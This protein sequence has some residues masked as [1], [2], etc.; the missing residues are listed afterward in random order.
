M[1]NRLIAKLAALVLF[2]QCLIACGDSDGGS[3]ADAAGGSGGSGGDQGSGSTGQKDGSAGSTA[4]AGGKDGGSDTKDAGGGNT[5]SKD[6]GD[7]GGSSTDRAD[8]GSGDND[9]NGKDDDGDGKTDEGYTP[10]D[11]ACG[12]GACA[13]TGSTSCVGGEVQDNCRPKTAAR[14]DDTCDNIDDDCDGKTDEDYV[15]VDNCGTGYC[16]THNT[17]SSCVD[18]VETVC[19]PATRLNADDASCDSV[20]DDCD[21]AA[22]EGY[23]VDSS[24]GAGY[25]NSTNT[26][27]SCA[28]GVETACSPGSPLSSDDTTCDG[29][30][31]DCDGTDDDDYVVNSTCGTGY[32]ETNNTPSSCVGGVETLCTAA[33]QNTPDDKGCNG[34]D[35]DCDGSTDEDYVADASCG[36]GPCR[37]TNTPSTCVD[38]VETPC[39]SGSEGNTTDPTCDGVDDDCDGTPDDDYASVTTS[40]G[41]GACASTGATSCANGKVTDSCIAGDPAPS[42]ASCDGVDD[43]CDGTPDDDYVVDASC[44]IGE[45]NA[46][47]TPSSCAGGVETLC[48]AGT[49][50]TGVDSSCDNK[51][52][53]CDSSFDEDYVPVAS[54]GI[55]YCRQ[56]NTPSS[57]SGGVITDC[58]PSDPKS[59]TDAT[60]D[61]VDDDCDGASDEDFDPY[62]SGS[63]TVTCVDGGEVLTACDD[64]IICTE[65]ICTAG[66]CDV[67]PDDS[68]CAD[69]GVACTNERCVVGLGC[70]SLTDHNYCSQT[71]DGGKRCNGSERCEPEVAGDEV[72]CV[73]GTPPCGDDWAC[74]DIV[75]NETGPEVCTT[76]LNHA[77][78]QAA[79]GVFCNGAEQCNPGDEANRDANGCVAGSDPC[80][81]MQ[82]SAECTVLVCNEDTDSCDNVPDD[83]Y[84]CDDGINCTDD[85]CDPD[86]AVDP[87][88]C[89]WTAKDCSGADT[90]AIACTVAYC[91]EADGSCKINYSSELCGGDACTDSGCATCTSDADCGND[92]SNLCD[93][94]AACVT[95]ECVLTSPVIDCNDGKACTTDL[96]DGPSGTCNHVANDS[97]CFDGVCDGLDA[98]DPGDPSADATTGCV[99]AA[100]PDCDDGIACTT[101]LCNYLTGCYPFPNHATCAAGDTTVCNGEQF[102]DSGADPGVNPSGCVEP[103]PDG[104]D[105]DDGIPCTRDECVEPSGSNEGGCRSTND[106]TNCPCGQSCDPVSGGCLTTCT[107]TECQGKLYECGDCI[108]NDN[109]CACFCDDNTAASCPV[110]GSGNECECDPDCS[111]PATSCAC[112]TASSSC[113][114]SCYCD[115]DCYYPNNG[116]GIDSGSDLSCFGP[117][118]NNESGFHGGIPGQ[119]NAPC[120][121]ECYFDQDTGAGNDDCYWDHG[122]DP[123]SVA[124]DYPPSGDSACEYDPNT[125]I[126][127][128]SL[129]CA[130]AQATQ[131]AVCW[132]EGSDPGTTGNNYCGSLVPNGC[133][134]FGCCDVP[135][136]DTAVYLGSEEPKDVGSCTLDVLQDETLCKPCTIVTACHNSCETCELCIGKPTLP[137]ECGCQIC[138]AGVQLCGDPCGSP[139]PAGYFCN[140]GC[141][142]PAPL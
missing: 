98:C 124:A 39:M 108:D 29:V 43:D 15:V 18:G 6:A 62:C 71:V 92:D 125:N 21:G 111:V 75:C 27:S 128:S 120:K 81:G 110:D 101:D 60:C 65:D 74:T 50:A 20:D 82:D 95:G 136:R 1:R 142:A 37:G 138:P 109:D 123:L 104:I 33:S 126:A 68:A 135:G 86:A 133:D 132:E 89:V 4:D 16:E 105:C 46:S 121:M 69:D 90:D 63:S 56:A 130:E 45:C 103:F 13:A 11:S 23:V 137:P 115:P 41:V 117:C 94:V 96:C 131:S 113:D 8:G 66:S 25:C 40:C 31:D 26:P 12:V 85:V 32:C 139:C 87:T 119:N 10:A 140:T 52:D 72:G 3:K 134:C 35:D 129:S 55:G 36:S 22:D 42:D 106:S 28:G 17:P 9:C 100:P 97:Y 44:G 84:S 19:A 88:G 38:G 57:C 116:A 80:A 51:D 14:D 79:D 47:N 114:A 7:G 2:S 24:C 5:D 127:G 70:Q 118:D 73:P 77:F 48:V 30:D 67:I 78:C 49:P 122:C 59:A 64:G 141:C 102:C 107:V 58:V 61:G 76:T 83:G 112:D 53:D 93:G 54:C 99:E 91:D 34:V